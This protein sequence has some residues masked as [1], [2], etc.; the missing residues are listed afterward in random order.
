M[1]FERGTGKWRFS[2]FLSVMW[3]FIILLFVYIFILSDSKC[4]D[5]KGDANG[6]G[7]V[8]N[9]D[10]LHVKG[11]LDG[12]IL[13]CKTNADFNNDGEIN[14]LDSRSLINYLLEQ[15]RQYANKDLIP[16][17]PDTGEDDQD[18]VR[19][20]ERDEGFSPDLSRDDEPDFSADDTLG[21]S[22]I[23]CDN[24]PAPDC[25]KRLSCELGQECDCPQECASGLLCFDEECI[26]LESEITCDNNPSGL[27]AELD[28]AVGERCESGAECA[29]NSCWGTSLGIYTCQESDSCVPEGSYASSWE[30]CCHPLSLSG[31]KCVVTPSATC[32]NNLPGID[33][34]LSCPLGS[35]CNA[36]SECIEG[37]YCWGTSYEVYTCQSSC[38]PEGSY[39]SGGSYDDCCPGLTYVNKK[40]T[41]PASS[42]TCFNNPAESCDDALGCSSGTRCDC[43]EECFSRLQC[44]SGI[45]QSP[46]ASCSNNPL[47][48]DGDDLSCAVGTSCD[49]DAECGSGLQCIG[50]TCQSPPPS[51]ISCNA[52]PAPICDT[53]LDCSAGTRCDCLD[54]CN[55]G[56]CWGT[57]SGSYT[58]QNGC[59]TEGSYSPD[60]D[61]CCPELM[62]YN[63]RCVSS[64]QSGITLPTCNNNP[65]GC[66]GD[67]LSCAVGTSCD[68][69]AECGSGL[70]CIGG[71]CQNNPTEPLPS[72]SASASQVGFSPD[73]DYKPFYKRLAGWFVK[74][75]SGWFI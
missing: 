11:H 49:C 56:Y 32:D 2:I 53:I 43:N 7:K 73:E 72:G 20:I 18:N 21:L 33:E 46:P 69:D 6:D 37:S 38:A 50:G 25:T 19:L 4:S 8:D 34:S 26:A 63:G 62:Q 40:C 28:C 61:T 65:A 39:Y 70:Q 12:G 5:T 10:V 23:T 55:S 66:N 51:S 35:K 71:T 16:T 22:A 27:N 14:A 30:D 31:G 15:G 74:E 54:E 47:G 57:S 1:E 59:A 48:C 24:N 58:C 41:V 60:S 9:F 75:I 67:D 17:S 36:R 3:V 29:S 42:A 13:N 68:C 44:I 52:N 45:C 64:I